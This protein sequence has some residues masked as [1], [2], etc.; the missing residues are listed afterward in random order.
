MAEKRITVGPSSADV[1]GRDNTAIQEAVDRAAAGGGGV[2]ELLEGDYH[3][4]DGVLMRSEV[5][6]IGAGEKT[7]LIKCPG[8][9]SPLKVDADY[10]QLKVTPETTEGFLP[11]MG[12]SISDQ[13][14][15]GWATSTAQI[16]GIRDGE[17]HLSHNL[18]KDYATP[19]G[20]TINNAF[21]VV[22][23]Y[24]CRNASVENIVVRGEKDGNHRMDGCRG[25]GIY[26]Y[27]SEDCSVIGCQV[28][29]FHGDGISFQITRNIRILDSTVTGSTYK[30]LHPGTGSAGVEARNCLLSENGEGGFFL[31]W[32]VQEGSFTDLD[33]RGNGGYGISIGH[34]DTDNTFV[35][36]R[37]T[38]NRG[39][40]LLFREERERNGA[41]RN[42]WSDCVISGNGGPGIDAH[43]V[44]RDNTFL[45]CIVSGQET[46]VQLRSGVVGFSFQSCEMEG[47]FL[48]E[49]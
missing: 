32:R 4:R 35:R 10:G 47:R 9:T 3:C 22:K 49:R 14:A 44:T 17:I 37:M 13:N 24:N 40:G 21:S 33:C 48:E 34:K 2:V 19:S 27:K 36:C 29:D 39:P 20:A 16:T 30:G 18:R 15:G 43:P 41:H 6:L 28:H 26:W 12:V 5:R 7:V 23:G 8:A 38:G 46:S 31:C 25:G 11:G 45:R 42:S 1:C